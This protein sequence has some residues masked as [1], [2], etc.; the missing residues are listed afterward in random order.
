MSSV[1]AYH[2][3]C[4]VGAIVSEVTGTTLMKA[5][6]SWSMPH[7]AQ[8]G[9]VLMLLF[10]G[11]SY[12]LLALATT[13]LPV[14]VAFA[15][16]EGLGLLFITLSSVLLLGEELTLTRF[17]ALCAVA[18]GVLLVHHGTAEASHDD[19][20]GTHNDALKNTVGGH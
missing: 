18:A 11:L 2:W 3:I 19:S 8:L 9:I 6:Q 14:G 7:G 17:A 12:Y 16:W 13:A 1:R 15:F 20:K 10:I 5:A 4:L